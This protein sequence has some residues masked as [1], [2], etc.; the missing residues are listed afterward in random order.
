[1]ESCSFAAETKLALYKGGSK[2]KFEFHCN[3]PITNF[4]DMEKILE[5][6]GLE[7][8]NVKAN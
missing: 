5:K 2:I 1:M 6:K 3:I 4:N 7:F 8:L